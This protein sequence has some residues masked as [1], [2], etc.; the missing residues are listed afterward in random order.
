M[1]KGFL[2]E[3]EHVIKVAIGKASPNRK[4]PPV[5]AFVTQKGKDK[6]KHYLYHVVEFKADLTAE[7]KKKRLVSRGQTPY[8]VQQVSVGYSSKKVDDPNFG[9]L[10]VVT[11]IKDRDNM[12]NYLYTRDTSV[13]SAKPVE[14][15]FPANTQKVIATSVGH[16]FD[17]EKIG[18]NREA[19]LYTLYE[20]NNGTRSL[21]VTSIPDTGYN[22]TIECLEGQIDSFGLSPSFHQNEDQSGSTLYIADEKNVWAYNTNITQFDAVESEDRETIE[23]DRVGFYLEG[24]KKEEVRE[25]RGTVNP[26]TL[27]REVW[28]LYR[29]GQLDYVRE[30]VKGSVP[31]TEYFRNR[32]WSVPITLYKG[33]RQFGCLQNQNGLTEFVTFDLDNQ[34]VYH[35]RDPKT[36]L[37]SKEVIC[38]E[39]NETN[40]EVTSYA[41]RV[42][43][44]PAELSDLETMKYLREEAKL[45]V[46]S[47]EVTMVRLNSIPYYVSET[48]VAEV[49]LNAQN[50]VTITVE[51]NEVAA[52]IL[53]IDMPGVFA[54]AYQISPAKMIQ[55]KLGT[56]TEAELE[57]ATIKGK[58]GEKQAL[59]PEDKRK[60]IPAAAAALKQ[61]GEISTKLKKKPKARMMRTA[62]A[63]DPE[64]SLLSNT[65]P[66]EGVNL[67][68]IEEVN[69]V[70]DENTGVEELP[71][72]ST[73][74]ALYD[75]SAEAMNITSSTYSLMSAR[76]APAS[77]DWDSDYHSFFEN[78]LD[79]DSF[80]EGDEWELN[81]VD[82]DHVTFNKPEPAPMMNLNVEDAG[83][84]ARSLCLSS[85]AS[86]PAVQY[87]VGS[88]ISNIFHE[89]GDFFRALGEGIVQIAKVVVRKIGDFIC[90]VVNEAFTLVLKFVEQVFTVVNWV[91]KKVLGIDL[92]DVLA[93]LGELFGW[94]DIKNTQKVLKKMVHLGMDGAV[95]GIQRFQSVANEFLDTTQEEIN[96]FLG[97]KVESDKFSNRIGQ[98]GQ[99]NNSPQS[100]WALDI[101]NTLLSGLG[102]VIDDDDK[103]MQKLKDFMAKQVNKV[104]DIF[105]S[106]IEEVAKALSGQ[107][108]FEDVLKKLAGKFANFMIDGIK[109]GLNL[110]LEVAVIA[111]EAMRK[112][113]DAEIKLPILG[114][115][116]K[117]LLGMELTILNIVTLVP[118]IALTFTFKLFAGGCPFNKELTQKIENAT[119]L[120][121]FAS[122]LGG[123]NV[124]SNIRTAAFPASEVSLASV[125]STGDDESQPFIAYSTAAPY[126]PINISTNNPSKEGGSLAPEIHGIRA[127]FGIDGW[128]TMVVGVIDVLTGHK[129][130]PLVIVGAPE[131]TIP[132]MTAAL[133]AISFTAGVATSLLRETSPLGQTMAWYQALFIPIPFCGKAGELSATL[134]GIGDMVMSLASIVKGIVEGEAAADTAVFAVDAAGS[135]CLSSVQ[136]AAAIPRNVHVAAGCTGIK[137][138]IG[139]V[140]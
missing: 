35:T 80:E 140:E 62:A 11:A 34:L 112:A 60:N 124:D 40:R 21:E 93:W 6:T 120:A 91:M 135:I 73:T 86:A 17:N 81:V 12:R 7:E 76:M 45:Q 39:D 97:N 133:T 67:E 87:S 9:V 18:K 122:V 46:R 121:D 132:T 82:S 117:T 8:P 13:A 42:A 94:E 1:T 41:I 108:S 98:D 89:I 30:Y 114:P 105:S 111:I 29:T 103:Q 85:E 113:L 128:V 33:I 24:G 14:M 4:I 38:G 51:V 137:A 58:N 49:A 138:R 28:I 31:D 2:G 110:I 126:T 19:M 99:V 75:V 96:K 109:S 32:G 52:P 48:E 3:D 119:S 71:Q 68:S 22:H 55:N 77:P 16:L 53:S 101:L 92:S 131:K 78:E 15:P 90:L 123:K 115:L 70:S 116:C 136:I 74:D 84:Q 36:S 50:A 56:L 54:N 118:A 79:V 26:K 100:N 69:L 59:I 37:W 129:N 104:Q 43:V 10:I 20:F 44:T 139:L 23:T 102:S 125:S 130:M 127:C 83:I 65:N 63:F 57:K 107:S 25:I 5:L 27:H 134:F 64:I 95:D 88:F 61:L 66:I 106:I 47:S 72:G